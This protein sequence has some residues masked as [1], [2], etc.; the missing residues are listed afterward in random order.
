MNIGRE[1][2][3]VCVFEQKL[4]VFGGVNAE[5]EPISEIEVYDPATHTWS[6]LH[7]KLPDDPGRGLGGCCALD[8][9]IYIIGVYTR[10]ANYRATPCP[11]W[12]RSIHVSPQ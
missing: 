11:Q 8:G 5:E 6:L 12:G 10:T 3:C 2:C 4:Y 7:A 1:G 9:Y